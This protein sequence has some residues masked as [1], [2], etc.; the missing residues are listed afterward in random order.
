VL[1]PL[2]V[3]STIQLEWQLGPQLTWFERL[4]QGRRVVR[5]DTRGTGLS[6]PAG[7]G[8]DFG[9]DAQVCD[10]AGVADALRLERFALLAA[11]TAGPVAIAYAARYPQR[12]ERLVLWCT[13]ACGA[14][15][16]GAPQARAILRLMEEDW[17]LFTQTMTH[18]RLG[19]ADAETAQH[20]AAAVRES[21]PQESVRAYVAAMLHVD[22]TPLLRQVRA[23][24]LVLHR[25]HLP[26]PSLDVARELAA[27]IPGAR[28]TLFAGASLAPFVDDGP[29][30]AIETFLGAA[31]STTDGPETPGTPGNGGTSDGGPAP[32]A[33]PHAPVSA[34]SSLPEPLTERE[35][36]VLRLMAEGCSNQE[37]AGRLV[38]TL[39]TAKTHVGHILRKLDADRRTQAIARARSLRL[40]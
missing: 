8:Y 18:S 5:Y 35:L 7:G 13:F 1:P 3:W 25:R 30:G 10:L 11:Q 12:V 15:Y 40:I 32:D 27:R 29:G 2:G 9:L 24:T 17:A 4:A 31:L 14:D 26:Y 21:V 28:L 38:V 33:A 16:Y 22:V 20:I 37:I 39:G 19:W 34:A 36:D 6:G 23:P